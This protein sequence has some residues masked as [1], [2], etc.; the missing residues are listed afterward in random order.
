MAF[1]TYT[2]LSLS[3]K[4]KIEALR[5]QNM[6]YAQIANKLNISAKRVSRFLRKVTYTD[7]KESR[8]RR[9]ILSKHVKIKIKRLAKFELK[10]SGEI[11]H[12][13][14]LNA[15][16]STITRFLSCRAGF[17]FRKFRSVPPMTDAHREARLNWASKY[18]DLG[19]NW[20]RVIFSDE[21]KFNLDGPDG[22]RRFWCEPG[23][24]RKSFYR[25][26]SAAGSVMVWGAFSSFGKS[27]IV[28]LDG[29]L[30]ST[31]YIE[32][33]RDNLLPLMDHYPRH[34]MLYQQDNCPVHTAKATKQW[35]FSENIKCMDWPS[36]SPDLNPMENMWA[37]LVQDVYNNGRQFKTCQELVT[38]INFCW[39]NILNE[40]MRSLINSMKQR[41]VKI[42]RQDGEFLN[43]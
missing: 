40:T 16:R 14:Q 36:L 29:R 34:T 43:Y 38:R 4:A 7:K 21:K 37:V 22:I 3:E 41:C 15:C 33:L 24:P 11:K 12:E 6:S 1:Q 2:H 19:E 5:E 35:L 18:V 42:L 31:K 9:E 10:T 25:R 8:G 30:S 28:I 20:N 17:K 39:N 13:L 32:I 26:H 27:N 23:M